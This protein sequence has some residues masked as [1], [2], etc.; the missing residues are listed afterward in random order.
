MDLL[1]GCQCLQELAELLEAEHRAEGQG[2]AT[3]YGKS[4]IRPLRLKRKK[5]GKYT[6]DGRAPDSNS[7]RSKSKPRAS[8]VNVTS[9]KSIEIELTSAT[10][11]DLPAV[12]PIKVETPTKRKHTGKAA[13]GRP[14]AK[15]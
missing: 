3:R 5:V 14:S 7:L 2:K 10:D 8:R 9:S 4:E 6:N 12:A 15:K 1:S 11:S 13:S